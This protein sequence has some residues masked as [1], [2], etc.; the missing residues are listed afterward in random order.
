MIITKLLPLLLLMGVLIFVIILIKVWFRSLT[1][2]MITKDDQ[3]PG[4]Y[5]KILWIILF[6]LVPIFAPFIYISS[7]ERN[8]NKIKS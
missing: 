6:L 4:K 5:D 7:V 3:F 2:I 1:T 8:N